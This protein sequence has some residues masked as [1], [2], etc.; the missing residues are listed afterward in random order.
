MP[1][2]Y[3]MNSSP[4]S[5]TQIKGEVSDFR[6][7]LPQ[8]CVVG[9]KNL[10]L[11]GWGFILGYPTILLPGLES[12]R[13]NST[14]EPE[15]LLTN[16]EKSWIGSIN[17]LCVPLGSLTSG[18]LMDALGKRRM[19][20]L[21]NF[22]M[23]AAWAIFYFSK[24]IT[25]IYFALGLSGM[26]GGLLEAPLLIYIADTV[27][28]QYRG[29]LTAFGT[30]VVL[31]GVC[32]QFIMGSMLH[33]RTVAA[34]SAIAPFVAFNAVFL[35]PESPLWLYQKN[36]IQESQK[37]LQWLRGWV[38]FKAVETE[39]QGVIRAVEKLRADKKNRPVKTWRNT[40]ERFMK[41]GFILPF[42]LIF[43]S[44]IFQH[45][46][47]ITPLQTYAF[48]ILI[49]YRVPIDEY[50]ATI[51]L[52]AAQVI[53]CLIGTVF[54][55]STGKRPLVF[56][57]FIGCGLCFFGLSM[58]SYLSEHVETNDIYR[59][60]PFILLLLG[61]ML[62]HSGAKLFPWMLIGEIYP[63]DVRNVAAGISSAIGYLVG[64]V[65]NKTYISLTSMFTLN[66]TFWIYS[67]V[68]VLGCVTLF[69]ILPETENKTLEHIQEFFTASKTK[70][71]NQHDE[72]C[73]E[74]NTNI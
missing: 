26:S 68:S 22:P 48:D 38:S 52:G 64:F 16:E 66:G 9:V 27:E 17:L 34:I 32:L 3:G 43:V 65:S 25:H 1:Q 69:F 12:K 47:G 24:N 73:N 39:F 57:S 56:A 74:T 31:G 72:K 62:G 4:N 8:F 11:L 60:L 54:I 29:M 10:I 15:F 49:F 14:A 70:R 2:N 44:F 40:L 18:L 30:G 71:P 19:M 21:L 61:T 6:R 7:A 35:V 42:S 59:W 23:M 36:R 55:R 41:R 53:G 33:W 50:Y 58:L 5:N 20:Q 46:S 63:L 67:A 45:F 37:S 28:P 13:D 51:F